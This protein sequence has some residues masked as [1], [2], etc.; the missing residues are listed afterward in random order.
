M[1]VVYG[2]PPGT[3]VGPV[4]VTVPDGKGIVGDT[5]RVKVKVP[6][7]GDRRR[8]APLLN[9]QVKE[10]GGVQVASALAE[11][12]R[13]WHEAAIK[14]FVVEVLDYAVGVDPEVPGSGVKVTDGAGL[15]ALGDAAAVTAVADM[16]LSRL[17]LQEALRGNSSGRSSSSQAETLPSD[18][19]ATSARGKGSAPSD[20]ATARATTDASTS[21]STALN[22]TGARNAG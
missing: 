1:R 4:T 7:D 20:T 5:F 16:V 2:P 21:P 9:V 3:V 12:L 22:S 17:G 11:N 13:A 8:L 18:G 14:E 19:T 15:V 6:S 10:E